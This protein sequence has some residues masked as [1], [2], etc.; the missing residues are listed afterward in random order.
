MRAIV[1][2]KVSLPPPQGV[3]RR[4]S[5]GVGYALLSVAL[6]RSFLIEMCACTASLVVV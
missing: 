4:K 1:S 5:P 3:S 2:D 6:N